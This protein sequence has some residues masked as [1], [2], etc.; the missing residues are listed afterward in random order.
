MP[1]EVAKPERERVVDAWSSEQIDK[2][3]AT[4]DE[5]AWAAAFRLAVL[6]GLRRSE[7]LALRWD[8]FK[9]K[10]GSIRVDEGLVATA[11]GATWTDARTPDRAA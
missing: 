1:R 11:G 6:S 10:E 9:P 7:L 5:H 4:T 3:L 2:F 8:D